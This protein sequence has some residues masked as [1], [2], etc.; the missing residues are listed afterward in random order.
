MTYSLVVNWFSILLLLIIPVINL[1]HNHHTN[2]FLYYPHY[3]IEYDLYMNIHK[4]IYK[5]SGNDKTRIL[6]LIKNLYGQKQVGKL[7]KKC[8][9]DKLLTTVFKKSAIEKCVFFQWNATFT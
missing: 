8:L 2:L 3:P 4:G 9:T 6:K 5:K 1:W 7:Q